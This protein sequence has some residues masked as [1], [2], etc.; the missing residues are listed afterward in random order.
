[1]IEAVVERDRDRPV[2]RDVDVLGRGRAPP[3]LDAEGGDNSGTHGAARTRAGEKS[4]PRPRAD[5]TF[6]VRAPP[7]AARQAAPAGDRR[8]SRALFASS[9]V[10]GRARPAPG[11]P[12]N[13]GPGSV[14]RCGRR[15]AGPCT[16]ICARRA[17]EEPAPPRAPAP[18]PPG[19]ARAGRCRRSAPS[20][21]GVERTCPRPFASCPT[22]IMYVGQSCPKHGPK[23][24]AA[25][26]EVR[27]EVLPNKSGGRWQD[28]GP[29]PAVNTLRPG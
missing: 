17:R 27:R 21:A 4:P 6:P 9:F 13:R 12:G 7:P 10:R 16:S 26:P 1:M 24:S 23:A 3:D 14:R 2:R 28:A 5:N 20:G 29:I 19:D 11:L 18:R 15:A 8:A 22:N 25:D